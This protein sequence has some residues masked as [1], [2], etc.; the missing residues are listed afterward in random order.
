MTDEPAG[1]TPSMTTSPKRNVR[2][3]VVSLLVL[4]LLGFGGWKVAEFVAA[5]REEVALIHCSLGPVRAASASTSYRSSP[6]Q[7]SPQG[8]GEFRDRLR[9]N[10][11]HCPDGFESTLLMVETVTAF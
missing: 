9:E 6:P 10:P 11:N 3:W 2:Q 4:I 1:G 7:P 8:R 5:K